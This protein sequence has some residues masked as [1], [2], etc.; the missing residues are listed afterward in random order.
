[1]AV[2]RSSTAIFQSGVQQ[3]ETC[4]TNMQHVMLPWRQASNDANAASWARQHAYRCR[5]E[6]QSP[7]SS[8]HHI[9]FERRLPGQ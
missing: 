4:G 5:S 8:Q 3:A 7:Q 1:M 9:I 2:P 6:R